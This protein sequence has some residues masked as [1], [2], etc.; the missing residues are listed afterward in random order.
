MTDLDDTPYTADLFG[1][2]QD[3]ATCTVRPEPNGKLPAELHFLEER[4]VLTAYVVDHRVA[5]YCIVN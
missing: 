4:Y 1:G 2:S 3:G 5:R